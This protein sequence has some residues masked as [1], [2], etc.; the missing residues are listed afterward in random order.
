LLQRLGLSRACKC[1]CKF[2]ILISLSSGN[3]VAEK[4]ALFRAK[5]L[6]L[7]NGKNSM[8]VLTVDGHEQWYCGS[9]SKSGT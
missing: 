3:P 4:D 9:G 7:I 5:W 1:G 6:R 2:F 8:F